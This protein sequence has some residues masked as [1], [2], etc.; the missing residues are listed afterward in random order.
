ML[1][2]NDDKNHTPLLK[3]ST[4][5]ELATNP[6]EAWASLSRDIIRDRGKM[7]IKIGLGLGSGLGLGLDLVCVQSAQKIIE[8]A[9]FTSR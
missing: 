1:K 7:L 3:K 5:E 9:E 2:L 4:R 6:A 8:L